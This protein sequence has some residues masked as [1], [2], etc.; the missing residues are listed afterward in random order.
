MERLQSQLLGTASKLMEC[1]QT[2]YIPWNLSMKEKSSLH[3]VGPVPQD[4]LP[5]QDIV[6]GI[7]CVG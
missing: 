3:S 5:G 6:Y 7:A 2:E 4:E 1:Q